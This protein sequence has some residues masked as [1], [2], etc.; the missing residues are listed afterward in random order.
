M[1]KPNT[2]P[3]WAETSEADASTGAE[4]K[5][6]PTEEFKL[7]GLKRQELLPRAFINYQFDLLSRWVEFLSQGAVV[8]TTPALELD[9]GNGGVQEITLSANSTLTETLNSGET[10]ILK[11]DSGGF[12]LTYPASF[13]WGDAGSPVLTTTDIIKMI[14]IGGVVYATLEWSNT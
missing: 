2:L 10:L 11:I 12:T 1:A 8:A 4:N 13:D 7:S 14:K 5:V 6:E 9:L 3:R